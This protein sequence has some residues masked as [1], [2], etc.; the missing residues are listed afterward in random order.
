MKN[1]NAKT[2]MS[3]ILI[4]LTSLFFTQCEKENN[5]PNEN[6]G[7]ICSCIENDFEVEP[8]SAL[9]VEAL[10]FMREEEKLARDVYLN[11]LEK[12]DSH[13]FDNIS[14][15]E[16]KHMD[17]IACLLKKYELEDPAD[18]NDEGE[19]EN[20]T[21]AQLY[22]ELIEAGNES[23]EGAYTVGA[24]IEDL[25]IYDLMNQISIADNADIKAVFEELTRG[26][27]NH[28]RAFVR[29][30]D[31]LEVTYTP[32]YI[33][34]ELFNEIIESS[35]ETGGALCGMC[36]NTNQCSKAKNKKNGNGNGN[37][38]GECPNGKMGDGVLGTREG[39][40]CQKQNQQCKGMSE[41]GAKNCQRLQKGTN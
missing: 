18:G 12:W 20:E 35:K 40:K 8:L 7:D 19:F 9:E 22:Q 10:L 15:S 23:L 1:L 30:L 6:T 34:E 33:E 11:L 25:D 4:L 32:Q 39:G 28:M 24:T 17:Y 36:Q 26:S 38:Y 14:G 27:R 31:K 16:Q 21:L 3:L 29:N 5:K 2:M 41:N 13:V 37:G